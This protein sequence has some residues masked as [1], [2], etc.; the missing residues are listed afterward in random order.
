MSGSN[1]WAADLK[2]PI[3]YKDPAAQTGQP[4][5]ASSP[6]MALR[7]WKAPFE[8][9]SECL[10]SEERQQRIEVKAYID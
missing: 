4:G 6:E 7:S 2:V 3:S 1:A 8:L 5:L 9:L 10:V